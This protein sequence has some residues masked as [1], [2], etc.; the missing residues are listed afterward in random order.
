MVVEQTQHRSAVND[1]VHGF[2]VDVRAD[3]FLY[4]IVPCRE[5]ERDILAVVVFSEVD[6]KLKVFL[7]VFSYC[8]H[9]V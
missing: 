2:T 6:E 9:D 7:A 4:S 3:V 1:T 5:G 8:L